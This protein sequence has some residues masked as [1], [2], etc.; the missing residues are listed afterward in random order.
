MK[1]IRGTTYFKDYKE[2]REKADS[3]GVERIIAYSL[4][5]AIQKR[6]SGP[7]WNEILNKFM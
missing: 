6:I 4:G 5:W 1:T 2:A 3:L 7:Y